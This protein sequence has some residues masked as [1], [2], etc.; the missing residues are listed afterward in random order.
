[1]GDFDFFNCFNYDSSEFIAAWSKV[2]EE[3]DI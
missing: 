2:D 1:M 3:V